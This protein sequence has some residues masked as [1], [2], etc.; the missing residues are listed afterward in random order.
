MPPHHAVETD[1]VAGVAG[2]ELANVNFKMPFEMSDEFPL[3]P[4]HLRTRDYSRASCQNPAMQLPP[5]LVRS[6]QNANRSLP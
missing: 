1:W 2:L 4:E 5:G 6:C 3:I